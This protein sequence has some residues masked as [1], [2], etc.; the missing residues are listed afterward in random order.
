MDRDIKTTIF[1]FIQS[2]RLNQ[3]ANSLAESDPNR[4]AEE[5]SLRKKK[6]EVEQVL[7]TEAQELL[8]MRMVGANDRDIKY[9]IT[10]TF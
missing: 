10:F 5:V 7:Q 3:L 1:H 4:R 8:R 9:K 6:A 2:G